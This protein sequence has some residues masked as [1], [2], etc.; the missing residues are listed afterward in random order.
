MGRKKLNLATAVLVA[1]LV[2]FCTCCAGTTAASK[3]E[4]G[5]KTAAGVES[6]GQE[7][8]GEKTA[9]GVGSTGQEEPGEKTAAGVGSKGQEGKGDMKEI[10]WKVMEAQNYSEIQA[11]NLLITVTD[12][13]P[14]I[15]ISGAEPIEDENGKGIGI[16]EENGKKYNVYI[17]KTGNV[18]AIK[19][20]ETGKYVFSVYE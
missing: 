3:E 12:T 11:E 9:A 2:F 19:D 8:S 6:T 18:F 10:I 16:T 14:G 17:D 5:E 4:S 15:V 13:L 1:A 20:M 7:E